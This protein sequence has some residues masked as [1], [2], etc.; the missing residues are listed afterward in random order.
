MH[1][2]PQYVRTDDDDSMSVLAWISVHLIYRPSPPLTTGPAELAAATSPNASRTGDKVP[3]R[4]WERNGGG[5]RRDGEEE[6][7][8]KER[9]DPR[10]D[11]GFLRAL[12]LSLL[13]SSL[14]TTTEIGYESAPTLL[15]FP[16]F[17]VCTGF[18]VR[19][20]QSAQQSVDD[21]VSKHST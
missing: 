4:V 17:S 16:F 12:V 1:N 5:G 21:G 9:E 19:L 6:E 14:P 18:F 15:F 2:K 10:S 11:G 8:K 7:T 13:L 3:L 20:L